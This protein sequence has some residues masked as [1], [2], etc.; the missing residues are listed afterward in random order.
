MKKLFIVFLILSIVYGCSLIGQM[1]AQTE[2]YATDSGAYAKEANDYFWTNYHQGNYDSIPII[3][4]KYPPLISVL[5]MYGHYP[6]DSDYLYQKLIS[7]N[8]LFYR[9][10]ILR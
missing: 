10:N 7:L 8:I 3:I 9:E 5:Y 4:D 1:S 6:K 2:N